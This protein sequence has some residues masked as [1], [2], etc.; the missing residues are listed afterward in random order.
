MWERKRE[1][2]GGRREKMR[3]RKQEKREKG[4]WKEVR[5]WD[6]IQAAGTSGNPCR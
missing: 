5:D 4:K 3:E 2:E 6:A 1:T